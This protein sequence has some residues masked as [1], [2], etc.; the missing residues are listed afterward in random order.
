[1]FHATEDLSFIRE[2]DG[3]VTVIFPTVACAVLDPATWAAVVAHMSAP[4][5]SATAPSPA[6]ALAG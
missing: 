5:Q 6:P 1:M 4:V 2:K 3:S